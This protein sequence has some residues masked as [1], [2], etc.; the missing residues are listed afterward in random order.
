VGEQKFA[1]IFLTRPNITDLFPN[2][3]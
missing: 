2:F 1:Q 3:R